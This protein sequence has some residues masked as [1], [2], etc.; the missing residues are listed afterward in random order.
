MMQSPTFHWTSTC[1]AGKPRQYPSTEAKGNGVSSLILNYH[2]NEKMKETYY[3]N[4][5]M[6]IETLNNKA[7][8]CASKMQRTAGFTQ[9]HKGHRK[10][11]NWDVI[12]PNVY[13]NPVLVICFHL[14]SS[15]YVVPIA[16]HTS[17]TLSKLL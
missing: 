16:Q 5:N 11:T 4:Q 15:T 14:L 1:P 10:H 7:V 9:P 6:L 8:V 17:I 13:F 12:I 3:Y 2:Q